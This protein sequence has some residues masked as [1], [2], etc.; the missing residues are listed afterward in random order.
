MHVKMAALGRP[1]FI[2]FSR[3]KGSS[4]CILGT[5]IAL[6]SYRLNFILKNTD[7]KEPILYQTVWF[8]KLLSSRIKQNKEAI[9]FI[10]SDLSIC[11]WSTFLE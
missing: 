8:K 10:F 4:D 1:S 6:L 7:G 2:H 11:I 5:H 9:S 3:Q